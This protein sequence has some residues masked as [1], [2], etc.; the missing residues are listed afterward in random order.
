MDRYGKMQED[1]LSSLIAEGS[2]D[3]KEVLKEKKL[4]KLL[5]SSNAVEVPVIVE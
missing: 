1:L 4:L 2:R 3:I 5:N